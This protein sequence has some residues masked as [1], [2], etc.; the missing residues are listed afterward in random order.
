MAAI[1]EAR[2]TI[3]ELMGVLGVSGTCS[4]DGAC[5]TLNWP[6]EILALASEQA[7]YEGS[8]KREAV[9]ALLAARADARKAKDWGRAD[10][11]RDG[12]T[13]LGFVIE[14]TPQGARVTYS[15]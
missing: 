3:V 2:D 7:G 5:E 1:T 12:L 9:D 4:D 15:A 8:N 13:G 6:D 14:D 10:A 11:V